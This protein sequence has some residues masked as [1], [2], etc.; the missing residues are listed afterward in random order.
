MEWFL[1][2]PHRGQTLL[3][4]LTLMIVVAGLWFGRDK[5]VLIIPCALVFLVLAAAVIPSAIPAKTKSQRVACT[6]H[7]RAIADAKA[8][9]ARENSK[10]PTDT[11][12]DADLYGET[13]ALPRKPE[14]PIGGSYVTGAVKDNPTCSLAHKGHKL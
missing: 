11:P 5:L 8:Q 13:K 10:Q 3:G 9:W 4:V 14:C 1:D 12:A 2:E 6:F 7:L